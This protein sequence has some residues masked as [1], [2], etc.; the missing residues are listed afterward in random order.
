MFINRYYLFVKTCSEYNW[1]PL[2]RFVLYLI[3]SALSLG[4]KWLPYLE[5]FVYSA[6]VLFHFFIRAKNIRRLIQKKKEDQGCSHI[7]NSMERPVWS[8]SS[9][10]VLVSPQ[11]VPRHAVFP[12]AEYYREQL[13]MTSFLKRFARLFLSL[14]RVTGHIER[15]WKVFL[16]NLSWKK[17]R[18]LAERACFALE[19]VTESKTEGEHYNLKYE[20]FHFNSFGF[21]K[22]S[23]YSWCFPQRT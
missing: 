18:G 9:V 16:W 3:T 20:L 11:V 15:L 19:T 13:L 2:W 1:L 4:W 17:I 12:T 10:R 5:R 21:Q 8:W 22:F 14:D 7:R 6:F 23:K